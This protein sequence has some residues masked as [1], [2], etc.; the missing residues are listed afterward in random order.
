MQEIPF[1]ACVFTDSL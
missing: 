1:M